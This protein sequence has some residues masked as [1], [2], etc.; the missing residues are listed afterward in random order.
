[1]NATCISQ[2]SLKNNHIGDD[3]LGILLSYLCNMPTL[4]KLYLNNNGITERSSDAIIDF[5]SSF[6]LYISW[7]ELLPNLETVSIVDNSSS[8]EDPQ[9]KEYQ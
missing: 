6:F 7:I 4:R 5:M 3:G 2:I 9:D 8:M 1:M